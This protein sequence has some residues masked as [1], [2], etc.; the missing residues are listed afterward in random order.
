MKTK[1]LLLSFVGVAAISWSVFFNL[2]DAH[3][4]NIDDKA[5]QIRT[6]QELTLQ[7]NQ[8]AKGA[9]K[10]LH[11]LRANPATGKISDKDV[12][13]ARASFSNF[14]EQRSGN[15]GEM[16]WEFMGPDDVGGRTRA[17]LV[18]NRDNSTLWAGSVAGGLWKSTTNGLSWLPV[19]RSSFG[20]LAISSICQDELGN[21]YIGTGEYFAGYNTSGSDASTFTSRGFI[22]DGIWKLNT[23]SELSKI[24]IPEI[25]GNVNEIVFV[26]GISKIF[27]A[28]SNGLYSSSDKGTSWTVINNTTGINITD[29]KVSNTGAVHYTSDNYNES[30]GY[31]APAYANPKLFSSVNGVDFFEKTDSLDSGLNR[32]ELAIAPSDENYIYALCSYETYNPANSEKY[33]N[34]YQSTD[35]GVNWN[36]VL[37]QHS[38]SVDLFRNRKQGDW[39]NIVSVFPNNPEHVLLGGIDLWSWTAGNGFEQISYWQGAGSVKYVHADQHNIVFHPDFESNNTIYFTSDGGVSVSY[40]AGNTFNTIN[41]NFGTTQYYAIECGPK[42]DVLGGLQDNGNIYI[43]MKQPSDPESSVKMP[44]GGDGGYTVVS[45]LYEDAVFWTLYHSNLHRSNEAG[46]LETAQSNS[47]DNSGAKAT[48]Q[49]LDPGNEGNPFVTPIDMWESFD[50]ADNKKYIPYVIDTVVQVDEMGKPIY[51]TKFLEGHVFFVESSVIDRKSF[52]YKVTAEDIANNNGDTL[53]VGDTLAV[54]EKF[55]SLM[56]I[57]GGAKTGKIYFTREALDFKKERPNW[58][59]VVGKLKSTGQIHNQGLGIHKVYYL[60]WDHLGESLYAI[61]S[62]DN[63]STSGNGLFRFTGFKDAYNHSGLTYSNRIINNSIEEGIESTQISN[64]ELITDAPID[65]WS[66]SYN[67]GSN[68]SDNQVVGLDTVSSSIIMDLNRSLFVDC[69]TNTIETLYG[70]SIQNASFDVVEETGYSL[71][72][73]SQQYDNILSIDTSYEHSYLLDLITLESDLCITNTIEDIN[74]DSIIGNT[75]EI[76]TIN[77]DSV[78][79]NVNIYTNVFKYDTV[80]ISGEDTLLNLISK[81]IVGETCALDTVFNYNNDSLVSIISYEINKDYYTIN[82]TNVFYDNIYRIDTI[83][84]F[85]DTLID[86]NYMDFT[87]ECTELTVQD[88]N[89]DTVSSFVIN[90][91]QNPYYTI[92]LNDNTVYDYIVSIDTL[93]SRHIINI[94]SQDT[95]YEM[96]V[97]G[98]DMVWVKDDVYTIENISGKLIRPFGSQ[99]PTSVSVDPLDNNKIMVTVSGF[100]SHD[101]VY[102][103]DDV[104]AIV[105]PW[106]NVSNGLPEA[107]AFSSLIANTY[108]EEG[109]RYIVGTEYGVYTTNE[110]NGNSTQWV[111]EESI[112]VVPVFGIVQQTQPNGYLPGVGNTNVENQGEIYAG[113]HG[114]GVWRMSQY[115]Q[116]YTGVK[117]LKDKNIKEF[118]VKV[119]PN[120]VRNY[121]NVEYS[122]V[123]TS[124]VEIEIYSLSGKQVYRNT[125]TNQNKGTFVKRINT[126]DLGNGVYILSVTSNNQRKV[127]KFVVE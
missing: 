66:V 75:E 12:L 7:A 32:I 29:V 108:D 113:T 103:S 78:F 114:L 93:P 116:P 92:T 86:I 60:K 110:L 59:P 44:F 104:S 30:S 88:I 47:F 94:T 55:S 99:M 24:D 22:G 27:A 65:V 101:K 80:S 74:T 63:G 15:S 61:A 68:V 106:Q 53:R 38:S 23:N 10:W 56:A 73:G 17:F 85:I 91:Y 95:T 82:T 49:N 87:N 52:E 1:H 37:S 57:G 41:K 11:M 107:S 42:G 34:L 67:N 64:L 90:T 72:A 126:E 43:D 26:E 70:D 83:D 40:D 96:G 50:Y 36:T 16:V 123:E 89:I 77:L 127:S 20:N 35:K 102:Y 25:Q 54:R 119:F 8:T 31:A 79:S 18:D 5:Y 81:T 71:M 51:L 69:D 6:E 28:T 115:K 122:V 121:A 46:K 120:P 48:L 19:Q 117:E 111:R 100:G 62:Y 14:E 13:A 58:E 33:F 98:D 125:I 76:E 45:E 4:V 3:N 118:K 9:A 109:N 105:T 97:M 39:N 84:H 2:F 21:I 124:D 112:P